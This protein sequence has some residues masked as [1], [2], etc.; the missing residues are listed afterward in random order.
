MLTRSIL[1]LFPIIYYTILPAQVNPDRITIARDR[2]GVPHIFAPTDA[3]VAYGFGWASAEDDFKT[4]QDLLLPI[5]GL[6]GLVYGKEG[7]VQDVGVHLIGPAEIVAERY[8]QDLS[9]SFRTYLEAFCAGINAYAKAHPEEVLHRKLFPV[10][11]P[12]VIQ[13]YLVGLTLMSG[14]DRDLS[15]II[16]GKVAAVPGVAGAGSNAFAISA[17]RTADGQTYLAINSHQPLEGPNSWY[18]AHLHSDE[19]LNI[20]GGTFAGAPVIH[21]GVN[22]YLGWAHT[23]NYPDFADVY[24]LEIHPT[25]KLT[26]RYDGQWKTLEPYH[27]KARIKLLGLIRFGL[28]QKFYRSAY[29]VTMETDRG[30]FALRFPA[31]RDIRA[32]EQWY[33]MNK[34]RNFEEFKAALRMQA[35]P[36]TNIIYADRADNIFYISNGRFPRRA[37]GYDWQ[38]TLPGNT[39]ATLWDD[40][41][42]PLDSLP[43]V[44][45]PTSGY[46]FNCNNTPFISSGSEDNPN[47]AAIPATMGFQ[48]PENINNRSVRLQALIES[49]DRI[50]Y[51]DFKRIKYDRAYHTPL[52]SAIKLESIFH[53]SPEQYP[54]L[55]ESIRL[56]SNWDRVTDPDSEAAA[57]FKLALDHL[58]RI[59]KDRESFRR[60]DEIDEAKLVEALGYAQDYLQ[61]YFG[62]TRA[63]LGELQR[64]RRGAVDLPVG[65]GRDV[66]AALNTSRDNDGRLRARAGE[67]Y[68]E[69]VRFTKD[70][71]E[72]ETVNAF[73]A[74]AK[75][76]SPHYTDQMEMYVNQELKP[77]TLDK[78]RIL[79]E[80][81]RIYH[82]GE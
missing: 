10:S 40:E 38:K 22:P 49:Y 28:K 21:L 62:R 20:L 42:Y 47:L 3:E 69:M 54:A 32:A 79:K 72:I 34:A 55:A 76:D 12:D 14:V 8:E 4:M 30:F 70:G 15:A 41:Y 50:S 82:P 18:E 80:A 23:L 71:V 81:V 63:T 43:Q 52:K 56:L 19:G 44:L 51:E 13:A 74:S 1:F 65:G 36:C 31:N 66:L 48:P 64:H 73:G 11:G 27:T 33:R 39:P 58:V 67:S 2:W 75:P 5:R 68:I 37:P 9:P 45:N 35:I 53:L 78:E 24:Q 60:G 26:Y 77:M 61:E 46:V 7:A 57:L 17:R 16:S 6:A 29:G 25:E 59:I